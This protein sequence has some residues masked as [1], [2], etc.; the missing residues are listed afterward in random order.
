[1]SFWQTQEN[2]KDRSTWDLLSQWYNKG[3]QR[4]SDA[5]LQMLQ[6]PDDPTGD[7]QDSRRHAR[8]ETEWPAHCTDSTGRSW[9]TSVV[10]TSIGGLGLASCPELE[11]D[12]VISI[13]L[14]DIGQ[15]D[16]RV[17]WVHS[18]RCGVQFINKLGDDQIRA[19]CD[20]VDQIG[21]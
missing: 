8:Y 5:A 15:F 9:S 1:M 11:V 2:R 3:G 19:M 18:N 4:P 17:A 14:T 10:D 7:R 21:T 13:Q 6:A 16:C 20:V 12:D